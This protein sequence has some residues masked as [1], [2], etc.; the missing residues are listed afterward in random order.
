MNKR[1]L[2]KQRFNLRPGQQVSTALD[3]VRHE[4]A[5]MKKIEHPNIVQLHEVLD[6]PD[7]DSIY[8]VL[9]FMEK[10]EVMSDGKW[11]PLKESD[12]RRFFRDM[13]LGLEYLHCN[14]IVHRDLKPENLLV[15]NDGVLKES[16]SLGFLIFSFRLLILVLQRLLTPQMIRSLIPK[17][18]LRFWLPKCVREFPIFADFQSMFGLSV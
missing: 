9:D 10:G 1:V 5:L 7:S 18:L 14:K 6:N 15:G 4:I 16:T 8:L 11:R 3:L 2:L 17:D 12:S 13:L